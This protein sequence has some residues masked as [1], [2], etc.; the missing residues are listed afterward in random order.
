MKENTDRVIKNGQSIEYIKNKNTAQYV[1][2]HYAQTSTNKVMEYRL[3]VFKNIIKNINI[4]FVNK[5][6][7]ATCED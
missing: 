3:H 5:F 1:E 7:I 4:L 2:N 6:V